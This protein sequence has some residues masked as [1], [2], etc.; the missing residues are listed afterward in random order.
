[1]KITVRLARQWRAMGEVARQR[2]QL[3]E[4]DAATG[5]ARASG[6]LELS[7]DLAEAR[8]SRWAI[9]NGTAPDDSLDAVLF[10]V[11][12]LSCLPQ[13]AEWHRGGRLLAD[14]GD[15]GYLEIDTLEFFTK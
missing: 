14:L 12:S 3:T 9:R 5:V 6:T 11:Y 4:S 7:V 8:A 1:M 2:A 10:T 13:C 15:P